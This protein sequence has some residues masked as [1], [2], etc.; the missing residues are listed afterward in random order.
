M[1]R[2]IPF[3][4]EKE[5]R[6]YTDTIKQTKKKSALIVNIVKLLFGQ[7]IIVLHQDLVVYQVSSEVPAYGG[8]QQQVI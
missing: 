4:K 8:V 2:Y 6:Q 1:Y 5:F 7:A 3:N